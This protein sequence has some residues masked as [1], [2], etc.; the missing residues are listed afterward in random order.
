MTGEEYFTRLSQA[1]K[2]PIQDSVERLEILRSLTE[3]V[4]GVF[5]GEMVKHGLTGIHP[6]VLYLRYYDPNSYGVLVERIDAFAGQNSR[7]PDVV[8]LTR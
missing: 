2:I 3:Y 1:S 4:D 6:S 8:G 5:Y 7:Y